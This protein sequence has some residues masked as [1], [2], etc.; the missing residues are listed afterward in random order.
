MRHHPTDPDQGK[1]RKAAGDGV[2]ATVW[3]LALVSLAV[4]L[5]VG[6]G[7]GLTNRFSIQ[8]PG[9]S[10]DLPTLP[11]SPPEPRNP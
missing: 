2:Q 4:L 10:P 3:V 9:V 8:S 7:W 6:V 5:A 11:G 1:M